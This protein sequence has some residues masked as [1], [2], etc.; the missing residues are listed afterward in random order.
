MNIYL[1]AIAV[2]PVLVL[3]IVVYSGDKYGKEPFGMLLKAFLF[4]ALTIPPAAFMEQ[5][6]SMFTPAMPVLSAVYTGFVVAGSSEELWKLLFLLLAIWGSRHFDEYYDGVVYACF[7]S[8][9]FA[10][11]ENVSYV[12]GQGTFVDA[13]SSSG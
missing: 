7:V 12:F 9:G 1:L 4:G 11:F 10:C 5:I 3:A 13:I 8:L 6:L 2:L